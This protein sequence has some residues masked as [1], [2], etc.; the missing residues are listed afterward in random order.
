MNYIL[1][2]THN[3]AT[4]IGQWTPHLGGS[5]A[6]WDSS[7]HSTSQIG[8]TVSFK[9]RGSV[10]KVYGTVPKGSGSKVLMDVTIDGATSPIITRT[11]GSATK[12]AV[13]FYTSGDM[14]STAWHTVV[15]TNRGSDAD[16]EFDRA[17]LDAPDV[18]PSV[19]SF[20]P[21]PAQAPS[22]PPPPPPSPPPSPPPPAPPASAPAGPAGPAAPDPPSLPQTSPST[23][24]STLP[25]IPTTITI[26]GV[27][28]TKSTSSNSQQPKGSTQ[29]TTGLSTSPDGLTKFVT[30]TT[31]IA[32][33]TSQVAPLN[34]AP[35]SGSGSAGTMP[36]GGVLG[37]LGSVIAVLILILILVV[38]RR[39]RKAESD[40][41]ALTKDISKNGLQGKYQY[42]TNVASPFTLT[43]TLSLDSSAIHETPRLPLFSAMSEKALLRQAQANNRLRNERE[44]TSSRTTALF[45]STAPES[46]S[47]PSSIRDT[48]SAASKF[49]AWLSSPSHESISLP[50][51]PAV[52]PQNPPETNVANLEGKALRYLSE[53]A[54]AINF[55]KSSAYRNLRYLSGNSS[56]AGPSRSAYGGSTIRESMYDVPPAYRPNK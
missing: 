38:Y 16:F 56:D 17:E 35:Q 10:C 24:I 9:F 50:F 30:T 27:V 55:P 40:R 13:L 2:D 20:A 49:E 26:N 43:P 8:A 36:L 41:L 15:I 21:A 23:V 31:G 22:P 1:D 47:A 11:T 48:G 29:P 42:Q 5:S 28:I 33:T 39:R 45:S 6:E 37:I 14:D 52:V 53:A 7:V 19:D 25:G 18:K 4:Y 12:Y 54:G 44:D 32:S 3:A 46:V 51:S 34:A